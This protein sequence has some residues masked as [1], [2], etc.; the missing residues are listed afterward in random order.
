MR[1]KSVIFISLIIVVFCLSGVASC[2]SASADELLVVVNKRMSGAVDIAKYYMKARGIPKDNLLV[3]SLTLDEVMDR[4]EFDNK[5][6]KQIVKKID[7]L[8]RKS[9]IYALVLIYGVPLKVRPP[10]LGWDV[11]ERLED[12]KKEQSILQKKLDKDPSRLKLI[13]DL[14]KDVSGNDKKAAVDSELMLVKLEDYELS[15]W[16]EN[17]YFVG[18]QSRDDSNKTIGKNDVILVSRLDGPDE[19]T[20]YRLIDDAIATE[21]KGL[22]GTAYFDA[23]WKEPAGEHAKELSGYALW[24]ASL[25]KAAALVKQRMKVVLDSSSSLFPEGSAPN[26]ALYSGW[27]SLAKY[28]DSFTWVQGAVAYHIASAEC[29]TLKKEDSQVW[30]MQML[31]RGVAATIGPVYEPYVQGF[32]LPEVFFGALTQGYMNLGES[33][34]ISLPYISWQMV[35]VGDPLYRPFS[36]MTENSS[37]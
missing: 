15:A 20:V 4:D 8:E 29:T 16:I 27:Y 17:P 18:F 3:T 22:E 10:E 37:Q 35:L 11:K 30:C 12:L 5:L 9:N 21:K 33:Y 19:K 23:R 36:P 13:T 25:H 24:D 7:T 28:V 14:I 26:A 32:P 2:Y 6:K 34:L 31:K 1:I